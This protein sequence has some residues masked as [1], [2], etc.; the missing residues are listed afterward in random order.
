MPNPGPANTVTNNQ[1]NAFTGVPNASVWGQLQG[2]A[3]SIVAPADTNE[4]SLVTIPIPAGILG[5]NGILRIYTEWNCTNNANVKT[6]RTRLGTTIAG[7]AYM[8][9]VLTS[10]AG[11]RGTTNIFQAGVASS[12]K[13]SSVMFTDTPT[14]LVTTLQTTTLD[15]QTLSTSN[16][17]LTAQ[18]ATGGDTIT[19]QSYLV[20]L[21]F[22]P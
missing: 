1:A 10:L 8:S 18:K 21:M 16:I 6:V 19:L 2:S 4:N 12:Q 9:A 20:E 7:T 3:I 22:D 15:L 13:G 17:Y 14:T 11:A 5:L